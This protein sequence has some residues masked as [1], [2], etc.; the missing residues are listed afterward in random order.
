MGIWSLCSIHSSSLPT[1]KNIQTIRFPSE[2][3]HGR[4]GLYTINTRTTDHQQNTKAAAKKKYFIHIEQQQQ[5]EKT[6][7]VDREKRVC[8]NRER[9]C[10]AVELELE[11][12][13]CAVCMHFRRHTKYMQRGLF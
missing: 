12:K 1:R 5:R 13:V 8:I 11:L 7:P 9:Q 4:N 3:I 2:R 6:G 10:D